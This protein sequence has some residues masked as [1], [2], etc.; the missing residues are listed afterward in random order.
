M[1]T[2]ITYRCPR[3][4]GDN[5]GYDA[6]SVWCDEAQDWVLGGTYDNAWCNTCGDINLVARPL[7]RAERATRRAR[8]AAHPL[9]TLLEAAREAE[10]ALTRA[11]AL[12]EPDAPSL[13]A[14]RTK[15]RKAIAGTRAINI[16]KA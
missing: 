4:D 1:T 8:R 12:V 5:V 15:L 9:A 10:A 16:W 3:C 14:R 11:I 7:T 2:L 13:R 6:N